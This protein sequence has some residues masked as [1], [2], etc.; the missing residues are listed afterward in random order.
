MSLLQPGRL[1]H[2]GFSLA[3]LALES[4]GKAA[5]AQCA[6]V[7]T[8][9]RDMQAQLL[10]TQWARGGEMIP[11]ELSQCS[12]RKRMVRR[13]PGV[14]RLTCFLLLRK[15]RDGENNTPVLHCSQAGQKGPR[16]RN[17]SMEENSS[18]EG[19]AHCSW[20]L[21]SKAIL[22]FGYSAEATGHSHSPAEDAG[23]AAPLQNTYLRVLL[24]V[25]SCSP[26]AP[27]LCPVRCRSAGPVREEKN[28]CL[29]FFL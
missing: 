19:P 12:Q 29:L 1:L 4:T 17:Q 23:D 8:L 9:L 5:L 22:T 24:A 18:T 6:T 14:G 13:L 10:C 27:G 25:W 21:I 20:D 28:C 7:E 16:F 3:A 26:T 15:T 2:A 11:L